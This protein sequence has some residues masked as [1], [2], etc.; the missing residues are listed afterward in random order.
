M[1][2]L[3]NV[4]LF[5]F[6]HAETPFESMFAVADDFTLITSEGIDLRVQDQEIKPG[7]V[8]ELIR[9]QDEEPEMDPLEVAERQHI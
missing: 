2:T 8:L 4:A 9:Y 7:M 5:L 3:L 1:S 6:A